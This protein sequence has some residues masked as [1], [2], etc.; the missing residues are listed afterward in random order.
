[1]RRCQT[2]GRTNLC[3]HTCIPCLQYSNNIVDWW[4]TP[5]AAFLSLNKSL[6]V[7][8]YIEWF[9]HLVLWLGIYSKIFLCVSLYLLIFF[10][11]HI[12]LL[13]GCQELFVFSADSSFS[14]ASYFSPL[15]KIEH[16]FLCSCLDDEF[17]FSAFWTHKK[18][19]WREFIFGLFS[20]I[21]CGLLYE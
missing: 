4:G 3:L 9:I 21:I 15:M 2:H 13:A 10:N 5:H 7:C 19:S 11:K 17:S 8:M 20:V 1:M 12:M 14:Y 16:F 6:N 18:K